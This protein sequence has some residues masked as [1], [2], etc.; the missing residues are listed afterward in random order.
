MTLEEIN[1]ELL[2]LS[3]PFNIAG[4]AYSKAYQDLETEKARLYLGEALN[5]TN[6]TARDS[7][8]TQGLIECGLSDELVSKRTKFKRIESRIELL[9]EIATNLRSLAAKQ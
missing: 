6:Q 8:V 2:D 9:R 7:F 5:Y 4:E 3:E 1:Q